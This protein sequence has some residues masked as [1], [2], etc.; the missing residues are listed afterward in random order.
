MTSR[1]GY[2]VMLECFVRLGSFGDSFSPGVS[3]FFYV[4]EWDTL[5]C[6]LLYVG[7][8]WDLLYYLRDTRTFA[9]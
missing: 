6:M 4:G 9:L 3:G 2:D 1:D 7:R 5:C 8:K